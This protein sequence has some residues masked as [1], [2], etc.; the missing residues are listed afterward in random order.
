[1]VATTLF[2]IGSLICGVAPNSTTLIVGRAIEGLGS[3]VI[4][5]GAYVA[6]AH[7]LPLARRPL[8]IAAV[9]S[10]YVC[11]KVPSKLTFAAGLLIQK[12]INYR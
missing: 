6:A 11:L 12:S 1:M 3:A 7:C 5:T 8:Y 9:G 10:M 4:L 2:N